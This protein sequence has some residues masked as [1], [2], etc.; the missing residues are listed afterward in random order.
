[1]FIVLSPSNCTVTEIKLFFADGT[2]Q[3]TLLKCKDIHYRVEF[4]FTFLGSTE[5]LC[6]FFFLNDQKYDSLLGSLFYGRRS[7]R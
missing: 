1:M 4:W 5:I 2:S 7:L 3:E 6:F